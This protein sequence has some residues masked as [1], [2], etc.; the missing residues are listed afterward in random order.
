MP[1]ES[2]GLNL[3]NEED[4][5]RKGSGD[6]EATAGGDSSGRNG[7]S[8]E[9]LLFPTSFCPISDTHVIT[10]LS[11]CPPPPY[12]TRSSPNIMLGI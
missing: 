12:F 7:P 2:F 6:S 5:N 1:Q 3:K 4:G 8:A 10:H 11:A 9:P